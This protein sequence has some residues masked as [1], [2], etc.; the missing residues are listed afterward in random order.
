METDVILAA[1]NDKHKLNSHQVVRLF[2]KAD[3][4]RP[5]EDIT[6][7][8]FKDFLK[9][10]SLQDDKTA[11]MAEDVLETIESADL[12][13]YRDYFAEL[14]EK[15]RDYVS[16]F[17]EEYPSR[18]RNIEK[19]PLVLYIDG[20]L[21]CWKEGIAVVGTRDVYEHRVDFI[22][23]IGEKLVDIGNT[24]VSGL[25]NGVDEAAHRSTL[26]AKGKTIAVLPGHI[27]KVY[28]KSNKEIGEQIPENGALVSEVS[29]KVRINRG[30]FVERNRITSGLS[31]AV[32]IGASGETGGTIHQAKFAQSQNVPILLYDPEKDDGQSPDKL[33]QMGAKTFSNLDELEKLVDSVQETNHNGRNYTLNEYS[34]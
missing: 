6:L 4:K 29:K 25:A 8:I 1:L 15:N 19:P 17:E 30:R 3:K 7:E 34:Q 20:E 14:K 11:S 5:L 9:A 33:K 10:E 28:P 16:I 31:K 13:F 12:D 26:E 23:K 2:E 18:L 32:V 22:E 27:E 21:S 24:V